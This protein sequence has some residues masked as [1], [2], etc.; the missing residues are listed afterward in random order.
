M[1][2][3][4]MGNIPKTKNGRA[5]ESFTIGREG[6]AKISA[7]EGVR[8][9]ADMK[10][11]FRE[12]DSKGLSPEERRREIVRRYGKKPT[13]NGLMY[14]AFPD[15]YCYRGTTV[16]KNVPGLRD[17][18]ALERFETA[19][20]AQRAGEPLPSGRLSVQHYQA[21]HRHLFQDVYRWAGRFR[22]V[23][24]TKGTSTFCYPE[25]I[26]GELQRIFLELRNSDYLCELDAQSFALAAAHFLSEL[27]A[28]HAFRDGNG[29]AQLAFLALLARA[30]RPPAFAGATRPEAFLAAMVTS[31]HR[32]ERPLALQLS[33]LIRS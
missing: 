15:P 17:A 14:A 19:I 12:F 29:R 10:Q 7:V 30:R 9:S 32:D 6:F 31:F 23:Q 33:E 26:K 27:N 13:Q 20:T 21:I 5:R 11:A 24:L 18:A 16:L 2:S 8:L 22:S 3:S 25:H 1:I 28:V 4:I